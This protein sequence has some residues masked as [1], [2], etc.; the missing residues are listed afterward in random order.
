MAESNIPPTAALKK[1]NR[2]TYVRKS[3]D[4]MLFHK[5]LL[6]GALKSRGKIKNNKGTVGQAIKW[7]PTYR[8]PVS[9]ASSAN[10]TAIQFENKNFWKEATLP[11]RHRNHGFSMTKFEKLTNK[12]E[13]KLFDLFREKMKLYTKAFADDIRMDLFTDGNSSTNNMMGFQSW[14]G[15][16]GAMGTGVPVPVANDTYAGLSTALANYAGSWTAPAGKAWPMGIEGA[17]GG[18]CFWTP[19]GIDVNNSYFSGDTFFENWQE[20]FNFACTYQEALHGNRVDMW[21]LCSPYMEDLRNSLRSIQTLE[22]TQNSPL[23]KMG[24]RTVSYL[25]TEIG[26]DYGLPTTGP[27]GFGLCFEHLELWSLLNQLIETEDDHDITTL[28]DVVAFYSY[29]QLITWTPA[30]Q[31]YLEEVTSAGTHS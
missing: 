9:R 5:S 14:T 15:N 21:L 23:T 11:W 3:L 2:D 18:Y 13:A 6:M 8:V 27:R 29:L 20:I 16:T 7:R 10:P 12:G 28:Q 31:I 24:Y 19:L 30:A 26:F 4:D 17:G 25:G 22:V 1:A